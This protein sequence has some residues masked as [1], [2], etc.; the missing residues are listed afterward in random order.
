M[1]DMYMK[2]FLKVGDASWKL[3]W[4][5]GSWQTDI[6]EQAQMRGSLAVRIVPKKEPKLSPLTPMQAGSTSGRAESQ[7]TSA[8]PAAAQLSVL[9]YTPIIGA[10][11][12]PGP[13]MASTA[14]PRL[15]QRSP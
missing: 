14:M 10:S 6:T 15:S 4:P 12:C 8:G 11:Y 1:P 7:S 3:V 13:S 9:K 2:R 5:P